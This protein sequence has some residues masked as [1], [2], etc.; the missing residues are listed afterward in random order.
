M[1]TIT[2][3]SEIH[4]MKSNHQ[5]KVTKIQQLKLNLEISVIY[6]AFRSWVAWKEVKGKGGS[7]GTAYLPSDTISKKT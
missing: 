5:A 6:I 2:I 3:S 7:R 4:P 1:P